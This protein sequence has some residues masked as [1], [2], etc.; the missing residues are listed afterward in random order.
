[1]T[2]ECI[3]KSFG[4]MYYDIFTVK[5]TFIAVNG[6]NVKN[7]T[8]IEPSFEELSRKFNGDWRQGL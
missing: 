4:K 2:S 8:L 3:A 1:M 7:A 6:S 5:M